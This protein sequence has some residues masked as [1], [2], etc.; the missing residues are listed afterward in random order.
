ML[1]GTQALERAMGLL[2]AIVSD[3]GATPV[4]DIGARMDLAPSSTRRMIAAL[5]RQGF[6]VRVAHGRYAGGELLVSL[7][8][9]IKP[10]RQL[11]ETARPLL[12]RLATAE[13]RTAHLGI[14]GAHDMVTYLVREGS[15]ALFTREGAELEAYCT[16]IGKAL[17]ALLPPEQLDNYL[18][19]SFV[20]LTA[21]TLIEP[22]RLR[23]EIERTRQ[24]GYA[25]DDREIDENVACVAVPLT[26]PDA[27]LAAISL[28]GSPQHFSPK[29]IAGQVRRLNAA[30]QRISARLMRHARTIG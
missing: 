24:R 30:A 25:I 22:A 3:D 19:G 7:A 10:H 23:E 5:K 21:Y 6:L 27:G 8:D 28:S 9:A 17:L 1:N 2:T 16:G 14:Y 15:G 18:A 29:D 12:R 20:Q 11:I 13:G 4:A 26:L